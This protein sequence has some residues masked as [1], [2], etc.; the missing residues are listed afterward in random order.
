LSHSL[1]NVHRNSVR[2]ARHGP[3]CAAERIANRGHLRYCGPCS[4]ASELASS[5]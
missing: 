1:K 3:R 4:P 5:A 2:A